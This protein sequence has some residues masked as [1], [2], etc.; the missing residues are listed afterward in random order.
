MKRYPIVLSTDDKYALYVAVTIQSLID[1]TEAEQE[2]NIFIL[3]EKLKE[4]TLSMFRQLQNERVK[5][6]SKKI[7]CSIFQ[8]TYEVDYFTTAMYYRLA[9]PELFPE[10]EKVLYIDCDIILKRNIAELF[11]ADLSGCVMGAI[12]EY[13]DE[14]LRQYL[15]SI[16]YTNEKYFNSGVLLINCEEFRKHQIA[17]KCMQLIQENATYKYP[18]QDI[19]NFT[20]TGLVY[21][22][23]TKWNFKPFYS[24]TRPSFSQQDLEQYECDKKGPA[25]V[26]YTSGYKPWNYPDRYLSA[27]WWCTAKN[28]QNTFG[29][30]GKKVYQRLRLKLFKF[31][32]IMKLHEL[33]NIIMGK[34]N[35]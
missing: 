12:Y 22:I 26:H 33:K 27:D 28:L 9:I 17:E 19:L 5:V 18:D 35:G 24:Y 13:A 4:K 25:L 30:T 7:D 11:D 8:S 1:T 34:S 29:H 31:Q 23:E 2:L 3:Y 14:G 15:A 32:I 10:Y 16:G 20:C 6:V 21:P